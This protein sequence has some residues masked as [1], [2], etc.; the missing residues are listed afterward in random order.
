MTIEEAWATG[1]IEGEGYFVLRPNA[2]SGQIGCRMTD[3]DVLQRLQ[4][5]WGGSIYEVKSKQIANNVH[6]KP[7]WTWLLGKRKDVYSAA[8]TML[9]MLNARRSYMVQNLL[10][11]LDGVA[12]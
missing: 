11:H 8:E 2:R 5:L 6:W 12:S 7:A 4:A 1:I 10:D 9:P 3:L